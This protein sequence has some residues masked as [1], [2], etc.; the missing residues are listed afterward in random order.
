VPAAEQ[1]SLVFALLLVLVGVLLTWSVE[2]IY[3]RD[4]FSVRM[5][6]V[7][8]FYFQGWVMLALGSAYALWHIANQVRLQPAV[9]AGVLAGAVVLI[10]AGMVYP[11]MA[12]PARAYGFQSEPNLDGASGIARNNP[13]DWAAIQWL[14]QRAQETKTVPVILEAPGKSYNYEGRISAFTGFPAVLGWAIHESQ[15]RGSYEE[16]G[17]REP[18]IAAIYTTNDPVYALELLQKWDVDYVIVGW[19]EQTYIQETCNASGGCNL[20]GALRKFNLAL[21]PVFTQGSV[22]IYAVPGR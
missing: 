14:R 4:S 11:V 12:F 18:D 13:D 16:Q 17:K 10:L 9:R 7:F 21:R 22:T 19:P 5:N 1:T 2:F 15:W 3:L 8:K 20:N 6:T